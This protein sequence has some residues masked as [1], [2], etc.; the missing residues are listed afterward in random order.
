M[1]SGNNITEQSFRIFVF[2]LF[3]RFFLFLQPLGAF[4]EFTNPASQTLHEFGDLLP[5]K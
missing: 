3:R 1:A 2:D 4:L 5:T